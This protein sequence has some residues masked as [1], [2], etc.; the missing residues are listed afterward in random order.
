MEAPP[1]CIGA[2]RIRL[3]PLRHPRMA[4]KH[5]EKSRLTMKSKTNRLQE[6]KMPN[7][8]IKVSLPASAYYD[9]DSFQ[10]I[11]NGILGRLGC[12]ACCSGWDLRC[13]LQLRVLVAETLNILDGKGKSVISG[14]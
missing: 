3:R 12:M 1:P 2:P 4:C 8:V 10:K 7:N 6:L 11:H 14:E 13:D 5:D 9:L